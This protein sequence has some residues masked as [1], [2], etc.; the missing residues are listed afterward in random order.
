[1]E[2]PRQ[3]PSLPPPLYQTLTIVPFL[4]SAMFHISFFPTVI[5][6]RAPPPRQYRIAPNSRSSRGTTVSRR[7]DVIA[8]RSTR[9]AT[10]SPATRPPMTPQLAADRAPR[11]DFALTSRQRRTVRIPPGRPSRRLRPGSPTSP[12]TLS[13]RVR[14]V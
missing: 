4:P 6:V 14:S 7:A 2:A 8:N 9:D 12:P 13:G 1:V 10:A 3:L 5:N 11:G